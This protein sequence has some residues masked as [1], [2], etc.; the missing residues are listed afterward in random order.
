MVIFG[1]RMGKEIVADTTF[2]LGEHKAFVVMLEDFP[3]GD[4]ALIGFDRNR[5]AVTIRAGNHQDMIALQTMIASEDVGGQIYPGEMSNMQVAIGIR[6]S[7]GY[8]NIL[9]FS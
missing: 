8:M 4:A 3:R 6:P 9:R 1:I 7:D 5:R 2:L